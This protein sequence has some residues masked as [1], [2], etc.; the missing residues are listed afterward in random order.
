MTRDPWF[1][2]KTVR[3]GDMFTDAEITKMRK[4]FKEGKRAKDIAAEVIEPVLKR[5]NEST[6]QDNDALFL[7][8]AIEYALSKGA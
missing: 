8:Y 5:V 3:I 6:G 7:A 4:L 2:P 1:L